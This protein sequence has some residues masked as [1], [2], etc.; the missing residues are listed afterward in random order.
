MQ[1]LLANNKHI[2]GIYSEY[3]VFR[4]IL[5][6][7]FSWLLKQKDTRKKRVLKWWKKYLKWQRINEMFESSAGHADLESNFKRRLRRWLQILNL[8]KQL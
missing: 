1:R 8:W 7:Q 6:L 5:D 3:S 4:Y 2:D